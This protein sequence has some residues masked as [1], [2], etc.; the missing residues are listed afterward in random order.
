MVR[1]WLYYF[2]LIIALLATVLFAAVYQEYGPIDEKKLTIQRIREKDIVA[3]FFY[4]SEESQLPLVVALG[5][6]GGG[7]LPDKEL[8]SLA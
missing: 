6:S 1:K 8:Q 7:F 2:L 5:G 3:D 4:P